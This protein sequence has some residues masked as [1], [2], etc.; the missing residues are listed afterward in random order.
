M[1][2]R[3]PKARTHLVPLACLVGFALIWSGLAIAPRSRT[4]WLLENLLTFV[5]VLTLVFSYRRLR[6]SDGVYV[7]GTLFLVLH[8]LGSHYTYSEV[9][10]GEWAAAA[11]GLGRNHYD[12]VVHFAFGLLLFEGCR[13]LVFRRERRLARPWELALS[14]AVMATGSLVYEIVEWLTAIVVDPAAGTAFVGDQGDPWDAQKDMGLAC[15]GALLAATMRAVR[16]R[17]ES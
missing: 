16:E 14:V 11:L 9:P 1:T 3:A 4:T 17:H 12:R 8:T 6:F 7:R 15:L 13:E 10:I 5:A 2:A